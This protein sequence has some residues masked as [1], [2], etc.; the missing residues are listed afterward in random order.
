LSDID[1]MVVCSGRSV[2]DTATE[3]DMRAYRLSEMWGTS[4][5]YTAVDAGRLTFDEAEVQQTA[6]QGLT[7]TLERMGDPRWLHGIDKIYGGVV[8]HDPRGVAQAFLDWSSRMR[9]DPG[10]VGHRI[11]SWFD[12]AVQATQRAEQLLDA[13]DVT[14]AWIN[15]RRA[16]GALSEVATERWGQRA[17]SL[18]RYWS[19]FEARAQ[20]HGDPATADR[21]MEA[22]HAHPRCVL[23]MLES[24]PE[25]LK[26]RIA[27]SYSARRLVGEAV[28]SA[29]NARDNVLA[30][31]MLYRGRFPS[32]QQVWMRA[33]DGADAR[34]SIRELTALT[35]HMRDTV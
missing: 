9:F 23:P 15:V 32:A 6:S 27:L 18:G 19:H 20:R 7:A 11:N 12:Q 24:I 1:V 29:Q 25:W 30:Y 35:R 8:L 5:I 33:E 10:V 22:V 31:A 13:G 14:G 34:A 4:G 28:T 17:G 16:G 21:I 3:V 26:D 2:E